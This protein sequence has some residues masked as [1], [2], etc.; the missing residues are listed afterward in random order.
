VW[1]QQ[2]SA[3]IETSYF[4]LQFGAKD[5]TIRYQRTKGT[6][7]C[8]FCFCLDAWFLQRNRSTGEFDQSLTGTP[9]I[10]GSVSACLKTVG[11]YWVVVQEILISNDGDA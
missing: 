1:Q 5:S 10:Y 3:C 6:S 8:S 2:F 4:P 9:K 7:F 11:C